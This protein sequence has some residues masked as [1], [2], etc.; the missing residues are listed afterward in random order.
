MLCILS[1]ALL[2]FLAGMAEDKKIKETLATAIGLATLFI[3]IAIA[4]FFFITNSIKKSR[5]NYLEKEIFETTYGVSGL[6]KEREEKN[7]PTYIIPVMP[8]GHNH[9]SAGNSQKIYRS[10]NTG[11]L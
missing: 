10:E 8:A 6:V 2:I 4:L 1:P 11:F 5:F 9:K 3:F 7:N